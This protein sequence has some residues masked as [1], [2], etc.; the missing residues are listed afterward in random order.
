MGAKSEGAFGARRGF[1]NL[2]KQS[3]TV[4]MSPILHPM[5][6]KFLTFFMHNI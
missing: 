5:A 3:H 1:P 2:L 4:Q 6:A